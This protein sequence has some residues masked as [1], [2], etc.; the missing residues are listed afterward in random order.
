MDR[1][2]DA[3]DVDPTNNGTEIAPQVI[4]QIRG[5]RL[6]KELPERML[7]HLRDLDTTERLGGPFGRVTRL[8]HSLQSATLAHR[9]G[10]DEEYVVVALLHDIGDLLAP[11]NHGDFAA[12]LMAPFISEA[13]HWMLANHH[14]FQGY[15]Y[16]KGLGLDRNQRE[17]FRGHPHFERTMTFC[18]KYDMP[19]FNPDLDTMPLEAFVPAVRRVLY[20][21]QRSVYI[22]GVSGK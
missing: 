6:F 20:N 18:E 5:S 8:V 12:T 22:P 2:R 11:Y 3:N 7:A 9:A 17:K 21:P 16:F 1:M 19:A 10:E 13:N 15:Y 4:P 14:V